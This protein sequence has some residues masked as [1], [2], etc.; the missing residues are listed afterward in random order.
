MTKNDRLWL[1]LSDYLNKVNSDSRKYFQI[2]DRIFEIT[3]GSVPLNFETI[4]KTGNAPLKLEIGFGNG[5]S[6]IKLAQKNP[7]VNYF[8]IDRKMDRIRTALSKLNKKD[9]IPNLL[10]SRTDTDY[11]PYIVPAQSFDEI[12]MN[13]PDPWPKKRHHKNRTVNPEF[14]NVIYGLLKP[15]GVF[16][17]ASDHEE[18]SLEVSE[19]LKSS[20]LFENAYETDFKNEIEN[21]IETQFEK[22]KKKEGFTIFHIKYRKI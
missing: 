16:R 13:F 3:P 17:F 8:G 1:G 9:K 22:H 6:L 5:E 19:M 2:N 7:G 12:I 20:E 14:L 15:G 10:I 18:Y 11:L 21:R 4:Y